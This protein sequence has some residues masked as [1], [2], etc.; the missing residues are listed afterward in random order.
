MVSR[1]AVR[2]GFS[3]DCPAVLPTSG[4]DVVSF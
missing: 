4:V 1:T 3:T 2:D